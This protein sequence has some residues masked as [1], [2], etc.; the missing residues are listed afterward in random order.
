[1][2]TVLGLSVGAVP[3]ASAN[4]ADPGAPARPAFDPSLLA[5]PSPELPDLPKVSIELA[6]VPVSSPVFDR[7][8]AAYA[9]VSNQQSTARD[10]RLA[11]DQ[12]RTTESVYGRPLNAS[13][14]AAL[15]RIA[16]LT[17]RLDDIERAIADM[18]VQAFVSGGN[19]ARVAQAL[20]S[21][22]PSINETDQ[23][24]VLGQ[25]S[26]DVLLAERAAYRERIASARAR[27]D[28]ASDGLAAVSSAGHAALEQRFDALRA[29]VSSGQQV[30]SERVT[31]EQARVLA[32]VDGVEFP[33]VALDAYYRAAESE[34]AARP[35]CGVEWWGVAGIAKVEGRHGTY[36]G[37]T[38]SPNGDTSRR[39]IGIQLNGTNTTAVI[40]D[41]DNGA[42]DG[43]A[44]YDRAI[45]PMQFIPSTWR[46]YEADGNEDGV[47]SPFNMYD[48]TL[49]AANYLCTASSGLSADRGLRAAYFS[50][51]HS[52]EY[53]E[54]VLGHAR[55][56]Q[57]RVD[58]PE[59]RD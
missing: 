24:A 4:R 47:M 51:N 29:E 34:G 17:E 59:R 20:T 1:M 53:V 49:A 11:I 37:A 57:R 56:Y 39:I 43:D 5:A 10:A 30:A 27:A 19:T 46:A 52:V 28:E 50:Y 41:T 40:P 7:A 48:A 9:E 36:G 42:F 16:G 14:V 12:A 35:G 26:M 8:A 58:V 2:L 18:A 55:G 21:E 22:T 31:Y 45:G 32:T 3:E 25:L 15:A 13:R 54:N 38:L 33:L 23:R 44:A 6:Q